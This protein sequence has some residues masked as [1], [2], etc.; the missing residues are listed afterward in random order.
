[1]SEKQHS[2]G[3]A[4]NTERVDNLVS[5][6]TQDIPVLLYKDMR[7]VTFEMVA[8]VHSVSIDTVRASFY[9]HKKR[10]TKGTHYFQLDFTEANQ[11][12]L[13]AT[14]S[15]NGLTVL[16]KKGYFIL[17]KP[18]QDN[19][20]WDVQVQMAAY[21]GE[22]EDETPF[23]LKYLLAP[24]RLRR[25]V[26]YHITFDDGTEEDVQ[27]R[28]PPEVWTILSEVHGKPVHRETTSHYR[29]H[30][31]IVH[32]YF[33]SWFD[34]GGREIIR[35]RKATGDAGGRKDDTYAQHMD[36][37]LFYKLSQ[38]AVGAMEKVLAIAQTSLK[39]G[40][41]DESEFKGYFDALYFMNS[42]IVGLDVSM[43]GQRIKLYS[44]GRYKIV[45]DSRQGLLFPEMSA[46]SVARTNGGGQL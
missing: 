23:A 46:A 22:E 42:N 12:L 17:V 8:R 16:T 10:F 33:Y 29:L 41:I 44:K 6:G 28:L 38:R 43:A 32:G 40:E 25:D 2:I 3:T 19:V 27:L 37:K 20:S 4:K 7:V 45:E 39:K 9:R 5:I 11:L 30:G 18:M 26:T 24:E 34:V 21:F 13:D 36:P 35:A 31:A 1:M 14:V 15:A